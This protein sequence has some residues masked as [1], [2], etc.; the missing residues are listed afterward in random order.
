V[1]AYPWT[2]L[3]MAGFVWGITKVGRN[4]YLQFMFFVVL[5]FIVTSV[6]ALMWDVCE[7]LRVP[8]MPFIAIISAYGWINLLSLVRKQ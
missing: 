1:L 3:W 4:L 6:G 5:Y 2:A 7:R 8:M